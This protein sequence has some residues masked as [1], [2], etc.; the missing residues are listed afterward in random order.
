MDVFVSDIHL[1]ASRPDTTERFLAFLGTTARQAA[2]LWIIGDLFEY[3]AGDDDLDDPF[4]RRICDAIRAVGDGG[5]EVRFIAGNRDFLAGAGFAR[6]AGLA[7]VE[8]PTQA[9]LSGAATLIMHGDLL[10]TGDTDYQA[11]RAMVRNPAWQAQFL[12]QPL[13]VR[14]AQILA[15]RERSENEKQRKAATIMDADEDAVGAALRE[16]GCTRLIHGHTHRPARHRLDVD[17]RPCERVVLPSWDED[18]QY[19]GHRGGWIECDAGEC[20]LVLLPGAAA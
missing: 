11:F 6:A 17:G 14:K 8:E 19:G 2:R 4:N 7:L 15:L 18:P 9:Q 10:C 1:C 16:S 5:V 13:A 20:R 12:G 3:W